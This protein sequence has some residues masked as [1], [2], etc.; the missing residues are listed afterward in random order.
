MGIVIFITYYVLNMVT[1]F[2]ILLIEE[3]MLDNWS[4]HG[5]TVQDILGIIFL[6]GFLSMPAA[7][8]FLISI[9]FQ[10]VEDNLSNLLEMNVIKGWKKSPVE[11]TQAERI[12][13]AEEEA[14]PFVPHKPDE[15]YD[16]SGIING[17]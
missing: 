16:D 5:V 14:P 7:V 17:V 1:L 11:D 13:K 12:K 8:F 4:T 10:T 3:D 9:G 2:F 15:P 6:G